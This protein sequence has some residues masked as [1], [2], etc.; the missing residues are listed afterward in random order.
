LSASLGLSKST[1]TQTAIWICLGIAVG[2]V[3][4]TVTLLVLGGERLRAPDLKTWTDDGG[5]TRIRR[6]CS[7][8]CAARK[9]TGK[10]LDR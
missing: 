6:R 1:L 9:A 4:G 2:K 8:A 7:P 10:S 3:V 5:L